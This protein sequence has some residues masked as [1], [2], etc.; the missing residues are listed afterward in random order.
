MFSDW[1]TGSFI[2]NI[3]T[4]VSEQCPTTILRTNPSGNNYQVE[5]GFRDTDNEAGTIILGHLEAADSGEQTSSAST[6]TLICI[7][8][9]LSCALLVGFLVSPFLN[10]LVEQTHF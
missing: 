7:I 2:Q 5:E 10:R 4:G 1:S 9:T 3:L 8:V 6:T